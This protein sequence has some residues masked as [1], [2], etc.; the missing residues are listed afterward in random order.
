MIPF[1][2]L[3]DVNQSFL[4]HDWIFAKTMP[5][6]PHWYTLRKAWR[7]DR[8]FEQAVTTIRQYGSQEQYRNSWYTVLDINDMRYW[9]MGAS[10]DQTI[11]INRKRVDAS[12][13]YD[14]IATCYDD[15]F[16]APEDEKENREIIGMLGSTGTVLDIGCG[17]GLLLDYLPI[18]PDQYTGI[19]PSGKMLSR[20][21]AKHPAHAERTIQTR[22]ETFVGG[23]YDLVISLFGAASYINPQALVRMPCLLSLG[24]RYFVMLFKPGYSPVTYKRAGVMFQHF[25]DNHLY[26]PPGATVT[27]YGNF[28]IAQGRA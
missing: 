4:A 13:D 9:T 21:H 19:D 6:N 20:L 28:L 3:E 2:L 1:G 17:T 10:L 22:F 23:R 8:A 16:C 12:A 26:L 15:L 7:D 25:T 27:E 18:R 14:Q 5:Q 24:G 11:L